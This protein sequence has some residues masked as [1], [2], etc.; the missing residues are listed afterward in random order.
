MPLSKPAPQVIPRVEAAQPTEIEIYSL[1][2][3][4][5][6]TG[7]FS[8]QFGSYKE[9]ANLLR[10]AEDLKVSLNK[11]V[12]TQVATIGNDKVYRLMVGHFTFRKDAEL[13][14]DK[15]AKIYSGCFIVELK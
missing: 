11:E 13:F 6:E 1:N 12:I 15:V 14:R 9:L 4:K 7:G 8:V 5:K 3:R 10:I 2:I